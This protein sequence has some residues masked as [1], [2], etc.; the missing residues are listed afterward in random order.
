MEYHR[1][2]APDKMVT[3]S[4]FRTLTVEKFVDSIEPII[5]YVNFLLRQNDEKVLFEKV[6]LSLHSL[7]LLPVQLI[8]SF[9]R[10]NRLSAPTGSLLNKPGCSGAAGS[11]SMATSN[12]LLPSNAI[13]SPSAEQPLRL[14]TET[15]ILLFPMIPSNM[16]T[17][18]PFYCTYR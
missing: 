8:L 18:F 10:T 1:S 5:W 14:R 17:P 4:K 7:S 13:A 12:L 9:A 11:T 6:C 3:V 16:S 15:P 2:D